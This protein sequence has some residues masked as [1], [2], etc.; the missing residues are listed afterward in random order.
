M[1]DPE[2]SFATLQ[3]ADVPPAT[4]V[5][6][7]PAAMAAPTGLEPCRDDEAPA[8]VDP[9][10][11][12]WSIQLID[13]PCA[14][15][16]APTSQSLDFSAGLA[17]GKGIRIGHPDAGYKDHTDLQGEPPGQSSRVLG[18]WERDF[19]DGDRGLKSARNRDGQHGLSTGTVIM[20][21]EMTGE[22]IGVAPKADLVALRVT[23]PRGVFPSPILFDSGAQALRDA[24]R[25]A[26]HVAG[27]HVISISLGWFYNRGLHAA[28]REAEV[29]DVIVCAAAGNYTPMVVWPAA[30]PEVVAVGGC[31]ATRQPW[32][33][34]ARGS[35]VDVSGPAENVWVASFTELGSEA[36]A[37]SSGTSFAVAT[38]AGVAALWLAYH[39]RDF[40]LE[41]YQGQVTLT[42]LFRH[43]LAQSSDPFPSSLAGIGLGVGIVNARKALKTPLPTLTEL[44][45]QAP[46]AAFAQAPDTPVARIA[47]A[48]PDIAPAVLEEWLAT[49][50]A[51]PVA[52]LNQRLA[53]VEEEIIF[54]IATDADRRAQLTAASHAINVAPGTP[55]PAALAGPAS[56]AMLAEAPLSATLRRR[57]R[58]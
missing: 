53:G 36:P 26:T 3:D 49:N 25:Y 29:A 21:A 34:S 47:A 38:V 22:I 31:T 55:A 41:R 39:N 57:L 51:I 20:S 40:L 37:Q 28:V 52:E 2:P 13:V 12:D 32:P 42:A 9:N 33:G 44:Q 56:T 58:D 18:T 50:L 46:A 10:Q 4:P 1:L 16:L 35:A 15:Q 23:K 7:I 24:I 27:C 6:P 54:Q 48:F 45:Q 19:V 14:W 8:A 43:V 11:V 30:Y 5:P 17:K